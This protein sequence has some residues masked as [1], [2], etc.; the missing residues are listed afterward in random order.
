MAGS[1]AHRRLVLAVG[2]E[3]GDQFQ[4]PGLA[5]VEGEEEEEEG[6]CPPLVEEEAGVADRA[7]I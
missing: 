5:E 4:N 1:P 2:E 3:E 7:P 6:Q